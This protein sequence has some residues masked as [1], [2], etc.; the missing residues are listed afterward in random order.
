MICKDNW[1]DISW[2][3]HS[4]RTEKEN[5]KVKFNRKAKTLLSFDQACDQAAGEIYDCY[6]NLYLALSGGSD[7]E[8][9]ATCLHRNGIPFTPIILRY[10]NVIGKDQHYESWFAKLWC[11]KH[12]VTPM[13]INTDDYTKSAQE[14]QNYLTV[15]PRLF[16]G[17]ATQGFLD[18]FMTQHDGKLISGNQ[19]EYYPDSDQ[20]IYLE[21]QLGNYQGFVM[22]ETDFYLETLHPDYH[23]WA[24]YYWSPEVMAGFVSAW[25][26]DITMQENKSNIYKTSIRPKFDYPKGFFSDKQFN[27]RSVVSSQKWGTL[28]CA[29][30]GNRKELLNQLLE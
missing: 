24:F 29:L 7:S 5:L 21:P 28:D 9:V 20:M 6:K 27:F 25:N 30:L 15:K 16:H 2:D 14:K 4:V 19:L 23:P 22:E 26:F 10:N 13:I 18:K 3:G 17:M 11:K 8:Y 12:Q 1:I